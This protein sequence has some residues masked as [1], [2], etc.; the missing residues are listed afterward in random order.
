MEKRVKNYVKLNY[1]GV[2]QVANEQRGTENTKRVKNSIR[3]SHAAI[4]ICL[5]GFEHDCVTNIFL[6]CNIPLMQCFTYKI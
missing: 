5:H 4:I 2:R 3:C 1:E 6:E